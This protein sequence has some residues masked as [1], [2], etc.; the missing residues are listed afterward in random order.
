MM[1]GLA[2]APSQKVLQKSFPSS[3]IQLQLG[4]EHVF[5]SLMIVS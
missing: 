1:S 4:C 2:D 3:T 5:G